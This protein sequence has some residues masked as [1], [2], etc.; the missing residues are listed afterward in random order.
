MTDGKPGQRVIRVEMRTS[1][2]PDEVWQAWADPERIAHWFVDRAEGIPEAG[3]TVT[4]FFDKFGYRMPYEVVAAE[5]GRRFALGGTIPGRGPF[6]LDVTIRREGGQTLVE[7]VNSGFLEGAEWDDEYDGVDSGWKKSL[8]ILKHYLENFRGRR[9]SAVLSMQPAAFEY[10]TLR[11]LFTTIEGLSKWLA[12]S[13]SV[14]KPGERY[15]IALRDG[16]RASGRV[17]LWTGRES[18]LSWDEISGTLE[19]MAFAAGP[20]RRMVGLRVV[21]WE[22]PE[23]AEGKLQTMADAAVGRLV[24]ALSRR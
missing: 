3:K 12:A 5:P 6:L 21:S 1:A 2:T 14:G 20:G 7:L 18:V 13:G 23:G 9:K 8:A 22:L 24:D 10:E 19:L 16:P 17:L 15:E 4:W 11:P